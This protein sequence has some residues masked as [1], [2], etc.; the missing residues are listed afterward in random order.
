MLIFGCILEKLE[1]FKKPAKEESGNNK[2]R[3][4]HNNN[5]KNNQASMGSKNLK[6]E[7]D[8]QPAE[9]GKRW[10]GST[11]EKEENWAGGQAGV[12]LGR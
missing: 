4:H 2:P 6:M 10:E 5:N 9:D 12:E 3:T 1:R 11:K 7:N 8:S